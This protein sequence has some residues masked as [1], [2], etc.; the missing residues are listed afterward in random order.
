[1]LLV[2]GNHDFQEATYNYHFGEW[3]VRQASLISLFSQHEEW[4]REFNIHHLE[5]GHYAFR[6]LV[7]VGWDG[8][9]LNN[10]KTIRDTV[11]AH[12]D[13]VKVQKE[14]DKNSGHDK[15]KIWGLP[16]DPDRLPPSTK[17]EATFEWMRKRSIE[18]F[19]KALESAKE[20]KRVSQD[21][22]VVAATHFPP[23]IESAGDSVTN[24]NPDHLTRLLGVADVLCYGHSHEAR[25]DRSSGLRL[26]NA[27][28]DYDKP[29][30][31]IFE[32]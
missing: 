5:S 10:F 17:G 30:Y 14:T 18:M 26:V 1:M 28:S 7:F 3:K 29:R 31:I 13:A 16:S 20:T 32:V 9:Y 4:F 2:R 15:G 8:W 23:F 12:N 11:V 25:D 21:F 27:G 6:D 24:G 22:K 19:E